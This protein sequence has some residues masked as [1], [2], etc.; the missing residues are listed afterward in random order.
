[1]SMSLISHE[2]CLLP[3]KSSDTSLI[4]HPE[5]HPISLYLLLAYVYL[6][7]I[8]ISFLYAAT[9]FS[10]L[11]MLFAIRMVLVAGTTNESHFNIIRSN[12]SIVLLYPVSCWKTWVLCE[13][14]LRLVPLVQ[15]TLGQQLGFWYQLMFF[16][17]LLWS[18]WY[19]CSRCYPCGL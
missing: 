15:L 11:F 12:S 17:F 14:F 16:N 13:L 10:L 9:V 2:I 5:H 1:M 4:Q 8:K 19:C 6:T 3:L 18:C 7:Y